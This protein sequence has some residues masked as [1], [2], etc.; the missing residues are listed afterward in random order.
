MKTKI[1]SVLPAVLLCFAARVI[2]LFLS[3]FV[4][5]SFVAGK[6]EVTDYRPQVTDYIIDE[7]YDFAAVNGFDF[8][9]HSVSYTVKSVQPD[10]DDVLMTVGYYISDENST[11]SASLALR[12]KIAVGSEERRVTSFVNSY[13]RASYIDMTFEDVETEIAVTDLVINPAYEVQFNILRFALILVSMIFAVFTVKKKQLIKEINFTQTCMISVS[14]TVAAAVITW[15]LNASSENGNCIFYP[16]SYEVEYYQPYVQQFDA[17]MKGQLH[18]DVQ[19]STGLLALEN[20]YS[21]YERM[22]VEHLFDRAFYDGKYYSYFGITP[23]LTVYMPIY[24]ITGVLPADSSVTGIFSVLTAVFLP[25]AV[26]EWAKFRNNVRP[27]FAGVCAVGAYFASMAI[28]VQRGRAPFYY[29]ASIGGMAFVSAFLCFLIVS[30]RCRKTAPKIILMFLAG[31]SYA[32]AFMSR[33]NSVMPVT[34][35]IIAFIVIYFIRSI[36]NKSLPRFFGEM[37]ALGVPVAAALA[38]TMWYNNARFSSP[39][40]FGTAYQLTVANTACYEFYTGGIIPAIYHYFVQQLEVSDLFPFIQLEYFRFGDY[41]RA[42]YVDSNFGIFAVPFMLSLFLCPWLL[43]SK[44]VSRS[45][46]ALLTVS[47]VSFFV[48]AFVDLCM[49]GV[50]FRYTR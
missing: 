4:W 41:G 37:A 39:F 3:N 11:A 17:F 29:I 21:P 42:L 13:G 30:F 23:L 16:L 27:W 46:K 50:I 10:A 7:N 12:E 15:I 48:T 36:K 22:N 38:F 25:V 8:P 32:L 6:S 35:A 20:P 40:Q 33:I 26:I 28:L 47:L 14:I 45:G 2:E 24:L 49:G 31:I 9:I 5:L 18:L 1:K 34:F 19:P 43:K 44:E